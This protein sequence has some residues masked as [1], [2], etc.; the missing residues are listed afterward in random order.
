[1]LKHFKIYITILLSNRLL[2]AIKECTAR[3]SLH[4]DYN[5]R[6]HFHKEWFE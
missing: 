3:K 4:S 2:R 5:Q 1:M 6:F